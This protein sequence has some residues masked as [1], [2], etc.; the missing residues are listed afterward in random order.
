MTRTLNPYGVYQIS[1]AS[2]GIAI[3]GYSLYQTLIVDDLKKG[4][5][6]LFAAIGIVSVLR[7]SD[8]VRDYVKRKNIEN[9]V[10]A[11]SNLEAKLEQKE[12]Q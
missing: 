3:C 2:T 10:V 6:G 5:V 11:Q 9:N 1:F 4:A 12:T 8:K 7:A